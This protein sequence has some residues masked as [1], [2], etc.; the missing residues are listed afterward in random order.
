MK[1]GETEGQDKRIA[2]RV[3]ELAENKGVSR[4]QI[5]LAWLLRQPQVISPII[6]ATKEKYIDDDVAAV[7]MTL[8]K[9]EMDYLEELYVP[10]KVVGAIPYPNN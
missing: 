1:Y 10:H 9:K 7:D 6:G 8:T 5:A 2:D 4:A 3:G